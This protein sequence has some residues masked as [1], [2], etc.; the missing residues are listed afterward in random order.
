MK[1]LFGVGINTFLDPSAC[2][3]GCVNDTANIRR[4][5][6]DNLPVP[7]EQVR[8]VCDERATRL[9]IY[10]RLDWC[11]KDWPASP[12]PE[13]DQLVVQFSC[14][15][16]QVVCRDGDEPS[17]QKDEVLCPYNFPELWDSPADAPDVKQC[18]ALL[19]N[20]A[21]PKPQICDDDLAIF[22][23]RIPKGVYT[24][25]IADACHSGS[26]SRDLAPGRMLPKF[27]PAPFDIQSRGMDRKLTR[28]QFGVT[29]RDCKSWNPRNPNVHYVDQRHIL[30]SGCRDD[31][32]SAD[33]SIGGVPQ[34]AMTWALL[35]A[36]TK[37]GFMEGQKPTWL[38]VHSLMIELLSQGGYEQVPQLTGPEAWL[39]API[40][41]R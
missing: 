34:G 15:G 5:C 31:Q 29:P 10:E 3:N 38:Q 20:G 2:L 17:D 30:L 1:K 35:A 6:V 40:F 37:L 27:V 16:S 26:I 19:G 33:A 21:L 4:F 7:P 11:S 41:L 8:L 25:L 28:R 24:V 23:K 9:N 12:A 39:H 14:H 18:A 36:V 22:L 32:T 13:T